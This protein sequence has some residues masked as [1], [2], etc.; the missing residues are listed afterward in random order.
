MAV[1]KVEYDGDTLIDLT[2]DTVTSDTLLEGVTAHDATG[3]S[4]VGTYAV[5]SN[6][7]NSVYYGT[8][9]TAAATSAK[10]ITCSDFVLETGATVYVKF[11][12]ANTVS[13]V[14]LNV[15]S[16]GAKTV[17][18]GSSTNC[19]YTW[20]A[21]ETVGFV[22]DGTYFQMIKDKTA[23]T[24][25]YGLTKLSSSISSTSPTLAANSAA[26][27]AMKDLFSWKTLYSNTL[28][29]ASTSNISI[30]TDI[31]ADTFEINELELT[32]YTP[33]QSA[34]YTKTFKVYGNVSSASDNYLL[35]ESAASFDPNTLACYG[36]LKMN[37]NNS[38]QWSGY[39]S[40]KT[41]SSTT[42]SGTLLGVQNTAGTTIGSTLTQIL[43]DPDGNLPSGTKFVITG[44]YNPFLY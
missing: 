34:A 5:T 29:S 32:W 24:S 25:Y 31:Q 20:Q 17:Y 21:N 22:Y 43:I 16:T 36:Y 8:C 33:S 15:N 28:S 40:Y 41:G 14:T 2:S 7:V 23:T 12:Y 13:S 30:T 19:S 11:T 44:R 37:C 26:V 9:S 27:K 6:A 38:G 18:W 39:A 3:A 10:S 1:N 42:S 4:I 35:F